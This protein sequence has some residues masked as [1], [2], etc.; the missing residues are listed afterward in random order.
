MQAVIML[1]FTVAVVLFLLA[2]VVTRLLRRSTVDVEAQPAFDKKN[3]LQ[4]TDEDGTPG[5][6][7]TAITQSNIARDSWVL[8][9][10][11]H[12][13]DERHRGRYNVL[14][15]NEELEYFFGPEGVVEEKYVDFYE[16][17]RGEGRS[18]RVI[19]YRITV[20][21]SGSLVNLGDGGDINWDWKGNFDRTSAKT[22]AFK[23]C[24][25]GVQYQQDPWQ[26][27]ATP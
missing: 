4:H 22:L 7:P 16:S 10:T 12:V 23:P 18:R 20:F 26:A 13:F 15:I 21:K 9:M 24:V 5:A 14:V 19:K 3:M 1:S 2:A 25:T 17:S 27:V 11:Q 6:L 8:R